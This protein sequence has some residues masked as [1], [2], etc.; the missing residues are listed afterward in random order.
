M[1]VSRSAYAPGRVVG[2]SPLGGENDPEEELAETVDALSG[3]AAYLGYGY[4]LEL[5]HSG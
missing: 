5:R 4:G 1:A 2:S 3:Y